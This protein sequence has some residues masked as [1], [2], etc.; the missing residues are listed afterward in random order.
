MRR[1]DQFRRQHQELQELAVE[2]G[3]HLRIEV[4]E[5]DASLCRRL[6]ARFAGK[7]RVHA[8]MENDALYPELL[9]HDDPQVREL[10]VRLVRELGPVYEGFDA[11]EARWSSA[12]AISLEPRAFMVSTLET[13][14][15][16]RRRMAT[17]NKQLYPVVDALVR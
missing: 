11:Y 2:I 17:E 4:L 14:E 10:A 1:S 7:L 8:A 9:R 6:V 12:H 15:M 16:L 3:T 13:F 5:Q